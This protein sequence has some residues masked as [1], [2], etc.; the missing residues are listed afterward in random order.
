VIRTARDDQDWDRSTMI[1]MWLH[2]NQ[3]AR[4]KGDLILIGGHASQRFTVEYTFEVEVRAFHSTNQRLASKTQSVRSGSDVIVDGIPFV[5]D[6]KLGVHMNNVEFV[7]GWR[8]NVGADF[9]KPVESEGHVQSQESQWA[10]QVLSDKGNDAVGAADIGDEEE[11]VGSTQHKKHG[12][13]RGKDT[14]VVK[15]QMRSRKGKERVEDEQG[16]D[17][18][19]GRES[20]E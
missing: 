10:L 18:G 13:K 6:G 3:V 19:E 2:V 9:Q 4:R 14:K 15:R 17:D 11:D 5:S 20:V 8:R 7:S 12:T 1:S 16:S